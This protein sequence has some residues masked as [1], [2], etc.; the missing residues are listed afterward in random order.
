[1]GADQNRERLT[2]QVDHS[3]GA[4]YTSCQ[5]MP[6]VVLKLGA[7]AAALKAEAGATVAEVG[8]KILP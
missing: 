3:L 6:L 4:D 1:V 5:A 2:R 7:E 8:Y